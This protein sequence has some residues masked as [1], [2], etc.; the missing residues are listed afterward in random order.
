MYI[1]F[2]AQLFRAARAVNKELKRVNLDVQ[3]GAGGPRPNRG[4]CSCDSKSVRDG[5]RREEEVN[6]VLST[7]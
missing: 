7:R 6:T 3:H 4:S 2:I 5:R 1:A